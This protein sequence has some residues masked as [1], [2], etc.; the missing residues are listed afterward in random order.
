[1]QVAG[2]QSRKLCDVI[3]LLIFDVIAHVFQDPT[4]QL[5]VDQLAGPVM[6]RKDD[7]ILGFDRH[8]SV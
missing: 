8:G 4:H 1:M 6:K 2:L 5:S 7:G 3:G